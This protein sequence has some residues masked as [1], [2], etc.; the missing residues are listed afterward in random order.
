MRVAAAKQLEFPN[1]LRVRFYGQAAPTVLVKLVS[2]GAFERIVGADIDEKAASGRLQRAEHQ[3]IF[4]VLAVGV[5]TERGEVRLER[6]AEALDGAEG[7]G[8]RH[9]AGSV[10]EI[11]RTFYTLACRNRTSFA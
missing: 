8:E 7:V 3:R 2:V 1:R 10:N 9:R 5:R 6:P 11:G 4:A